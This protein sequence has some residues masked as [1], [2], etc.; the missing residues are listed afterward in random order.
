MVGLKEELLKSIWHAFTALDLDRSGKVSKS[1]LKASGGR[2]A[3]RGAKG[4]GTARAVPP[5]ADSAGTGRG[6]GR[7]RGHTGTRS[8]G[9]AGAVNGRVPTP[10]L[11]LR[12]PPEAGADPSR[13]PGRLIFILPRQALRPP[14][15][16]GAQTLVVLLVRFQ[17]HV[18]ATLSGQNLLWD[19]HKVP[20]IGVGCV[21]VKFT[22]CQGEREVPQ[23][24]LIWI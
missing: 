18:L 12:A 16:V 19:S 13:S 14:R 11:S 9:S 7:P 1:Q 15:D 23:C 21:Q 24:P 8:R 22:A 3:R 5:S 4:R 20:S 10:S 2:R 17:P 6:L